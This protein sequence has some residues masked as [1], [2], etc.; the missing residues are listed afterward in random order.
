MASDYCYMRNNGDIVTTFDHPYGE[1]VDCLAEIATK[2][3]FP[4][5]RETIAKYG[6]AP[7]AGSIEKYVGTMEQV[8]KWVRK[9]LEKAGLLKGAIEMGGKRR[10]KEQMLKEYHDLWAE[11]GAPPSATA[12]EQAATEGKC[13]SKTSYAQHFGGFAK[14][15]ELVIAEYGDPTA[16][17]EPEPVPEPERPS[18]KFISWLPYPSRFACGNW[19]SENLLQSGHRV[20]IVCGLENRFSPDEF[21]GLCD[22]NGA[23]ADAFVERF[24]L[25][26][27]DGAGNRADFPAPEPGVFHIV[28]KSVFEAAI[29]S[30]RTVSD[31]FYPSQ[32]TQTGDE[33]YLLSE[34]RTICIS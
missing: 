20:V 22:E 17:K 26:I 8:N 27:E 21:F 13:A 25:K 14:V 33:P 11:L 30:G 2:E 16:S 32:K 9:R 24:V 15:R 6:E 4:L 31:L 12:V 19:S 28:E 5:T 34:L 1:I 10:T 23:M 18:L 7:F 3:G 29:F